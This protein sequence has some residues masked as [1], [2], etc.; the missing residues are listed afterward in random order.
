MQTEATLSEKLRNIAIPYGI[1]EAIAESGQAAQMVHDTLMEAADRIDALEIAYELSRRQVTE[2]KGGRAAD[3]I[4]RLRAV[5][6]ELKRDF[7]DYCA[8]GCPCRETA[9]AER[10]R[11]ITDEMVAR[12]VAAYYDGLPAAEHQHYY[13]RMRA[14][15]EAA[16]E[17]QNNE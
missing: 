8:S 2:Q 9:Q 4:E 11:T 16:L 13:E 5:I 14:A 15:L 12:V 7:H 17:E 6:A 3:E 10:E 1:G